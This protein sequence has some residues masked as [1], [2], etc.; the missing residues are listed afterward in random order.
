[1][2][3]SRDSVNSIYTLIEMDASMGKTTS[4]LQIKLTKELSELK[5]AQDALNKAM[6]RRKK[7]ISLILEDERCTSSI[8]DP[9]EL[10]PDEM[11]CIVETVKSENEYLYQSTDDDNFLVHNKSLSS[12]LQYGSSE[13]SDY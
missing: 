8:P 4:E 7:E 13:D 11:E 10:S 3:K 9:P 1:M 6:Q 5:K 12:L 2:L